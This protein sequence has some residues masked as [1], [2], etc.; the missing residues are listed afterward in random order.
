[1]VRRN[2]RYPLFE[3]FDAPDTINSCP[4]RNRSTTAPQALLLLNSET[5]LASACDLA[6]YL[7]QQAPNDE[8]RI[9][10]AYRR[11]L[12]RL[13]SA[14]ETQLSL[15]FLKTQTT[16][17]R[18]SGRK[19]SDLALPKSLSKDVAPAEAAALVQFCLAMFNLNEF[20]YID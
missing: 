5:S 20:V 16:A 7:L 11:V 8:A 13:P 10:L 14:D 3:A 19:S 15:A 9:T 18:D 17:V 1:M 4:E 6:S 12:S 2:L